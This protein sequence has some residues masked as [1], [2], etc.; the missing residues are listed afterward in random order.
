MDM[1][2]ILFYVLIWV[3]ILCSCTK[4]EVQEVMQLRTYDSLSVTIDYPFLSSYGKLVEC[5][6]GDELY[7]VGYNRH[8]HSLDFMNLSG[9]ENK[10]IEFQREGPDAMLSPISFCFTAD[11]I[12][13]EDASGLSVLSMKGMVLK[14]LSQKELA[15]PANKNLMKPQGVTNSAY[16]SLKGCGKK[17]AFLWLLWW[18]MGRFL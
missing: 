14:R 15:C 6:L 16:T 3:A 8:L 10:V 12:V 7:A 11:N 2:R 5:S 4:K 13:W 18:K 17:C 1:N 9:G